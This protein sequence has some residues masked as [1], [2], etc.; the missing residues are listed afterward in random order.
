MFGFV[1]AKYET[2]YLFGELHGIARSTLT[3]EMGQG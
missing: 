3:L 1:M 2:A